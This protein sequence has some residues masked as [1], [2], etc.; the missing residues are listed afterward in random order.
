MFHIKKAE[1]APAESGRQ[2]R[3]SVET[4]L[5]DIEHRGEA[6]IRDMARKFDAWEGDESLFA[7][8]PR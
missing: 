4:M 8:E 6:A 1:L 7:R 3:V 2:V 5:A